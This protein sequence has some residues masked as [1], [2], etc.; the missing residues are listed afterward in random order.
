MSFTSI[1]ATSP[2]GERRVAD[3]G[4]AMEARDEQTLSNGCLGPMCRHNQHTRRRLDMR[5]AHR[6]VSLR[7]L[8]AL[9][10][11]ALPIRLEAQDSTLAF[12]T[13]TAVRL[14]QG[15]ALT[16]PIARV[17]APSER[18]RLTADTSSGDF[19]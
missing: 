2:C 17:L 11:L 12:I 5:Y 9:A 10:L 8:T 1:G 19:W 4:S 6:V 14:R 15:P 18:V 3:L 7:E 13:T 16:A